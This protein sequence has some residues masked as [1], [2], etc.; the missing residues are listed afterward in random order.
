[1]LILL[2]HIKGSYFI[3]YFHCFLFILEEF[4]LIFIDK[5]ERIFMKSKVVNKIAGCLPDSREMLMEIYLNDKYK[6]QIRPIYVLIL[7]SHL[8]HSFNM[9][10]VL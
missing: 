8:H 4:Y 3:N 9:K 7:E 6:E 1:M 5:D 10:F 2:E